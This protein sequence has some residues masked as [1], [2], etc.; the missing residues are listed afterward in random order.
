MLSL[1][2][3]FCFWKLIFAAF[4]QWL[5]WQNV[6]LQKIS[7]I[8]TETSAFIV[9]SMTDIFNKEHI[10][11]EGIHKTSVVAVA[12]AVVIQLIIISVMVTS[13]MAVVVAVMIMLV[14]WLFVF[15]HCL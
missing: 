4:C 14:K 10:Y 6:F 5:H 9:S 2:L 7:L 3:D 8:H 11:I 15:E 13:T 1:Q 12:V